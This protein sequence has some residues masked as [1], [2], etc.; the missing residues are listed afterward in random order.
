MIRKNLA[1][2]LVAVGVAAAWVVPAGAASSS[3]TVIV[4]PARVRVVQLAFQVASVK[5]VG[6]VAYNNSPALAEPLIHYWNGHEWKQ[7][8]REEYLAGSFLPASVANVFILGDS[9]SLPVFMTWN[10]TWAKHT[11]KTADLNVASLLNEFG[12]VLKFSRSDWQWLA[13]QNELTL[14]DRNAERRRFGR[15][16]QPNAE[17]PVPPPSATE[18][19][20]MTLPPATP[21]PKVE[22]PTESVA[23]AVPAPPA[24]KVLE[25]PKAATEVPAEVVKSPIPTAVPPAAPEATAPV[26]ATPS[27]NAA[28]VKVTE[29]KAPEVTIPATNAP[30]PAATDPASK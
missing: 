19:K 3:G 7:I 29:V 27:T 12:P 9:T 5:D 15:W 11:H 28:A 14:D 22:A 1:G 18:L 13:D 17:A 24:V 25:A 26:A 20:G 30:A 23:P 8:T 2:L 16:A 4:M 10:P 21:A 6:L